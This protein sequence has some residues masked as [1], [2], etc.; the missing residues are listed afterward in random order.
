MS[1]IQTIGRCNL[2]ARG[3]Y[4]IQTPRLARKF[5]IPTFGFFRIDRFPDG[6]ILHVDT[7]KLQYLVEVFRVQNIVL[8]IHKLTPATSRILL[9]SLVDNG[10]QRGTNHLLVRCL[11]EC[12]RVARHHVH[13]LGQ[14]GGRVLFALHVI[15]RIGGPLQDLG[16]HLVGVALHK[17]PIGFLRLFECIVQNVHLERSHGIYAQVQVLFLRVVGASQHIESIGQH[18]RLQHLGTIYRCRAARPQNVGQ[19]V[20]FGNDAGG[21]G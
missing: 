16:E 8:V 6:T 1:Q 15:P 10:T 14:R 12:H 2:C 5:S 19:H 4:S 20:R 9:Q 18:F 13:V 3:S 7:Q 17:D 11:S 21:G